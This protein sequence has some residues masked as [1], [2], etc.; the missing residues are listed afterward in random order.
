M[1]KV[2]TYGTFDLLHKGHIN[3][4]KRAKQFGDYLI[5]GV[6]TEN[7][8]KGRGKLNVH[9]S[10]IERIKDVHSTNLADEIIVEEYEGQKIEDIQKNNIDVFVIGSDWKGKFDYLKEYC[11]VVYLERTKGI[12]STQLRGQEAKTINIGIVGS[13]RIAG[14]FIPESKYVSGINVNGVYN[15]NIESAKNFC[16]THELG[17]FTDNF[18]KFISNVDAVYIASP[19]FSHAEYILRSLQKGKHVLCEKPM[20]L[21]AKE[22]N[23]LYQ[24]ADKQGLVLMEAIKTAYAPAFHQLISIVKSGAIG[25][26]KDIDA[27]FTKL[28]AGDLRELSAK[29][30]GG[31]IT[32]LA[33]YPLL[34]IIK[35]LGINYQDVHF[36]SWIS[37]GVDLF[38]RGVIKY[39]KAIASFKVG[40]GVKTEGDLIISGTKGYAYVPAP[41][42]KTEYFELRF[43]DQNKTRK[44]FSKFDSDGLRYEI[45]EFTSLINKNKNNYLRVNT[46]ESMAIIGIIEKFRKEYNLQKL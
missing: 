8:D 36:Y 20:V 21:K 26:I 30:A 7:Y 28:S 33:T 46:E 14:R 3:I 37:S 34:P 19:H 9:K 10:T 42:W 2:I 32:E 38:T 27:S 41:W 43:E 1:K 6:T 31:S 17:F 12:S 29:Q 35:I 13:G 16:N 25:T 11:E 45:H 40:L 18:N 15:P 44:Y 22:A 4:L 39:D 24:L 23:E 5:V